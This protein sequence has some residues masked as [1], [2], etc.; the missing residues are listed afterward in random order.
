VSIPIALVSHARRPLSAAVL[1]GDV[2]C[3]L[4]EEEAHRYLEVHCDVHLI[5]K[6]GQSALRSSAAP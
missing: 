3:L 5:S 1:V 4:S 2:M 6:L